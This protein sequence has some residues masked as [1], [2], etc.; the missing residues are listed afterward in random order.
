MSHLPTFIHYDETG[1]PKYFVR[2]LNEDLTLFDTSF[3]NNYYDYFYRLE[4]Y[5]IRVMS[6]D[7]PVSIQKVQDIIQWC[8]TFIE[9]RIPTKDQER[10]PAGL[11]QKDNSLDTS[12]YS[13]MAEVI[14][15]SGILLPECYEVN[16]KQQYFTIDAF[17]LLQ[18]YIRDY[19]IERFRNV[20]KLDIAE[21][22]LDTFV[23]LC[24]SDE[25][26]V[27]MD[28]LPEINSFCVL[29]KDYC[30]IGFVLDN[31]GQVIFNQYRVFR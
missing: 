15:Y 16:E 1:R 6:T 25:I 24:D 2:F 8:F 21:V 29:N 23:D 26:D 17:S 27:V 30:R 11:I 3:L 4:G 13:R 19:G 20:F 14:R 28:T 5:L 18:P 12:A 9:S 7:E 31:E 22:D 10:I